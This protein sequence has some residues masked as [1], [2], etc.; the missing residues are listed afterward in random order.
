M[1]TE[2]RRSL[3]IK[4]VGENKSA[5][6]SELM[7]LFDTSESTIRRDLTE[8]DRKGALIKVFGGAVA[9]EDNIMTLDAS[10][11]E[12]ADL[13]KESKTKIA[14]YAASLIENDDIVYIDSGTT[15]A[16]M[17]EHIVA[18]NATFVTNSV[19]I[20]RLLAAKNLNVLMPGG[21]L[22]TKTEALI[23]PDTC[24]YLLKLYFTKCFVGANGISQKYGITT[25]DK[26]EASVKE[27]AI[28]QSKN[29]FIL[30]DNS[31]FD[32]ICAALFCDIKKAT[33]ITDSS[34]N[35]S[36]KSL[37]NIITV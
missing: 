24:E 22:K 30:A 26:Q 13:N 14:V 25:P 28:M 32:K 1:L 3:I 37:S 17:V 12:R 35:N 23:G 36:Y 4:I 27:I 2:E 16:L 11:N 34:I 31:K 21:Q 18:T 9:R 15:T 19:L 29:K 33:I 10:V 20:A 7:E 8:L 6:V 5:S